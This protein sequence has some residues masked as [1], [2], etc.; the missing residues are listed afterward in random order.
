MQAEGQVLSEQCNSAGSFSCGSACAVV[1]GSIDEEFSFERRVT[2]CSR[3]SLYENIH[4]VAT[5]FRPD[6]GIELELGYVEGGV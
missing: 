4:C 3:Q 1:A 2:L 5:V 6:D